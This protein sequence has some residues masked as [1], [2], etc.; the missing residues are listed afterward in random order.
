MP[1]V[2]ASVAHG[3][4]Y[5][6]AGTGTAKE[7]NILEALLLTASLAAGKGLPESMRAAA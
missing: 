7:D 6:I 1:Y 2:S 4:A 3:T 5:D